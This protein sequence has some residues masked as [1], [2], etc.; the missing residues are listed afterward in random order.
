M[1]AYLAF[2][3]KASTAL[4]RMFTTEPGTL[5]LIGTTQQRLETLLLILAI[6]GTINT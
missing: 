2:R 5:K 4:G 3:A 1:T 6:R